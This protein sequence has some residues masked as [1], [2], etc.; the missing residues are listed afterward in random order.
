MAHPS[1]RHAAKANF[2]MTRTVRRSDPRSSLKGQEGRRCRGARR[3]HRHLPH[4]ALTRISSNAYAIK[5]KG[6]KTPSD[7]FVNDASS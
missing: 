5:D 4:D 1:W 2:G 6:V 3:L 7:R